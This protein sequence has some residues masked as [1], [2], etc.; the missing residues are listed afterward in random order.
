M[1]HVQKRTNGKYRVRYRDPQNRERSRTFERKADAERFRADV[2]AR[3]NTGTWVTPEQERLPFG[4]FADRWLQGADIKASTRANYESILTRWVLPEFGDMPVNAIQW[5]T[6]EGFKIRLSE[7]QLTPKTI[8]NVFNVISPI[9]TTA[10]RDGAIRHNPARDVAKPRATVRHEAG[11]ASA[12]EVLKLA[13]LLEGQDRL[14]VIFAAFT[15]LRASECG[16]LQVGDLNFLERRV[17][18]RRAVTEVH[19]RVEIDTPKNGRTR[20][21]PLPSFLVDMLATYLAERGVDRDPAARV[22]VGPAG[23]AYRHSNFYRRVFKPAAEQAGL[24]DFRFHD[25][26]HTYAT[27]LIKEGAHP[28]VVMDR[29]GHSSIQ[30]T[31]NTYGHLF[32]SEDEATIDGLD[33]TFREAYSNVSRP[34]RG[35]TSI[36]QSA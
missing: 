32:P 18:V 15:G 12:D 14:L 26:R 16:G 33:R 28:R 10:V 21:V 29:M 22:F 11:F 6:L 27:L 24:R 34:V 13:N 36:P 9:L 20:S 31:M 17:T 5:S 25:L 4:H 35:L 8:R 30:L 1:A 23:G 7:K 2:T 19:G 3:M